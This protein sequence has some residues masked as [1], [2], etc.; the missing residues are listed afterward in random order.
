MEHSAWKNFKNNY[1]TSSQ[2]N[3]EKGAEQA[4]YMA[5]T[6]ATTESVLD[7]SGMSK[8][9]QVGVC[10]TTT[11]CLRPFYSKRKSV[12]IIQTLDGNN[13]ATVCP[14]Y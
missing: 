12:K 6:S 4:P 5:S 3:V 2:V 13:S 11:R 14:I 7:V 1:M 10:A 8:I 9:L